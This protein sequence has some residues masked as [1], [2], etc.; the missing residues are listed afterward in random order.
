MTK[1]VFQTLLRPDKRRLWQ[2]PAVLLLLA[3]A[4]CTKVAPLY[5]L[6]TPNN[7]PDTT[8]DVRKILDSVPGF[9]LFA[10]ASDRAAITGALDPAGFYTLFVPTDSAMTAAGYTADLIGTMPVDSLANVVKYYITYNSV[11]DTTL[12]NTTVSIQQNC[13]LETLFYGQPGTPSAGYSSYRHSLFVKYYSGQLNINGWAVNAGEQPVR[14]SNGYLYPIDEVLTPPSQRVWDIIT[15]RPEL[16]FYVAAMRFMDSFYV[17]NNDYYVPDSVPFNQVLFEQVAGAQ[18]N[19]TPPVHTTVL[20][21]TNTAFINAGLTDIPSVCHFILGEVR[22]DTLY[23]DPNGNDYLDILNPIPGSGLQLTPNAEN[24]VANYFPMD[25]ALKLHY[26]YN[27]NQVTSA[28]NGGEGTLAFTNGLCYSDLTG[29][30]AVNNGV[31]N[32]NTIISSPS[33]L[34]QPYLLRFSA[35]AGGLLPVQWNAA[36]YSNATIG[37]DSSQ[38]TKKRNFWALNGVIYESDQLFLKTN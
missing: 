13:L 34:V 36:A 20:A 31:L 10:Q 16:S 25:S 11:S 38:Q 32:V 5:S 30:P 28:A 4:A 35:G 6:K 2:W 19:N 17:A 12:I 8:R 3:I 33:S 22:T 15:N 9:H 7:A 18:A 24:S 23:K 29:S 1:S 14:A 21:P 37:K 27:V 26:L